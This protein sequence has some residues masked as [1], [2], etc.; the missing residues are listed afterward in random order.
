MKHD[1]QR[2]RDA[3]LK[4]C[5][6]LLFRCAPS[7]DLAKIEDRLVLKRVLNELVW[8]YSEAHPRPGGKHTGCEWWTESALNAHISSTFAPG[9]TLEL[10]HVVERRGIIQK[11]ISAKDIS[12]V[13]TILD[14]IVTCVVLRSEHRH[15]TEQRKQR[16]IGGLSS[17]IWADYGD[18]KRVRGPNVL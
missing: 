10:D 12:E 14:S 7:F 11:I 3:V 2:V 4:A 16:S 9:D 1:A 17:D 6:S 5:D 13:K 15:I 8:R 18:I